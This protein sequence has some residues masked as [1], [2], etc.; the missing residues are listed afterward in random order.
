MYYNNNIS[1]SWYQINNICDTDTYDE[2]KSIDKN[3]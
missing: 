3:K 1:N 2:I